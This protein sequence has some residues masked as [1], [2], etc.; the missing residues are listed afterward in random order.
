MLTKAC[1]KKIFTRES[2]L[3]SSN[4]RT[5][6]EQVANLKQRLLP[7]SAEL[8]RT[9]H[10]FQTIKPEARD[11]LIVKSANF[12]SGYKCMAQ[13][14]HLHIGYSTQVFFQ[15]GQPYSNQRWCNLNRSYYLMKYSTV[16]MGD[17]QT[18]Q[19]SS[20]SAGQK[21]HCQNKAQ[22]RKVTSGVWKAELQMCKEE[23]EC[24]KSQI[25]PRKP[26]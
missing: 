9:A 4:C 14:I 7:H 17:L 16:L 2:K 18:L 5:V 22:E 25:F 13:D 12:F 3:Q 24:I 23:T 21:C 15:W 26:L 10:T 11:L 6:S 1:L 19:A 8:R 20:I